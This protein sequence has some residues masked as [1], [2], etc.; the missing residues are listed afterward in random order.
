[1]LVVRVYLEVPGAHYDTSATHARV[2]SDPSLLILPSLTMRHDLRLKRMDIKAAF[3][4]SSLAHEVWAR[5]LARY[6]HPSG[7][8]VASLYVSL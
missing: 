4:N 7:H 6:V 2:A 5:F 8:R 3:L 1:M